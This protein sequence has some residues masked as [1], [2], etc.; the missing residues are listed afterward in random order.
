MANK[1][2]W[3][4]GEDRFFRP[5][6]RRTMVSFR[7]LP[8]IVYAPRIDQGQNVVGEYGTCSKALA[9]LL[10]HDG[11]MVSKSRSCLKFL[12]QSMLNT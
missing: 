12:L 2:F 9:K 10:V 11:Q 5:L 8:R 1:L 6:I 3:M 7:G 4:R